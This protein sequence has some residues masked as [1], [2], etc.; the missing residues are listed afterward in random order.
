[1]LVLG[2]D[3]ATPSSGVAVVR[4][5]AEA[6][7][8]SDEIVVLADATGDPD[9]RHAETLL[10]TVDECLARA[11]CALEEIDGIAVTVG[12]GSFTGL[13]VGLATAKGL[14]LA[15]GAWLIGAPTLRAFAYAFLRAHREDAHAGELL[16]VCL[17]A[18]RGEVYAALFAVDDGGGNLT[19]ERRLDTAVLRPADLAAQLAGLGPRTATLRVVGDGALRY[20]GEILP[21]LRQGGDVEVIPSDPLPRGAAAAEI[22]IE[23]F[24]RE[25]APAD[26]IVPAYLRASEAERKRRAG[27]GHPRIEKA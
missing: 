23:R 24:R 5:E 20:G 7:A 4:C 10:G 17:D 25:G 27:A 13:R 9:Q 22:A 1:V 12:P 21:T 15:T 18:R 26:E 6:A 14:A 11:G 3:T 16:C 19:L 8:S 2:I